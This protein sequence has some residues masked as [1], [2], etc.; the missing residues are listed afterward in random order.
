M[1]MSDQVWRVGNA[2][3]H[4]NLTRK[5]ADMLAG[6]PAAWYLFKNGK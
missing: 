1:E 2:L 4:G 3:T 6:P 5:P